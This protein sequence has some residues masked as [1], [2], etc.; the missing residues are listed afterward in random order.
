MQRPGTPG[1]APALN[2][3]FFLV[4]SSKVISEYA[5]SDSPEPAVAMTTQQP[6]KGAKIQA[7]ASL[8]AKLRGHLGSGQEFDLFLRRLDRLATIGTL[9]ASMAHEIKNALVAGKTFID[10][11]LE[12]HPDAELVGIVRREM[13]RIDSIVNQ[14]LNFAGPERPAFVAVRLHE[15][16]EHSLRLVQPQLEDKAIAISRSFRAANDL[17]SGDDFQLQQVFVNLLLNALEAMGANGRL[18]I[19]TLAPPP[20]SAVA[21]RSR[22]GQAPQ[23]LV[24]IKDTGAG[25]APEHMGQLFEPFFTTKAQGT[26]LGLAITRHIIQEHGGAIEVESQLG[27]GTIFRIVLPTLA[28][29]A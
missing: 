29:E 28:A 7:G 11:L 15:V 14:M 10:L 23:L 25:I 21:R 9:S 3:H 2:K 26:G 16:L 27:R 4:A 22:S 13:A 18:A 5:A 19:E 6:G 20:A 1:N 12:Q 17:V 8:A 24:A